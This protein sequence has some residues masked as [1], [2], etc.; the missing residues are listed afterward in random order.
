MT[1]HLGESNVMTNSTS[2][3]SFG[4]PGS[5]VSPT[6]ASR[7]RARLPARLRRFHRDES[8][9]M[10]A[11]SVFFFLIM[12][13]VGGIGVDFMHY[14]M[15]RTRLQKTLDRAVL[16][17]ADMQ[18]EL[19]PVAVVEDYLNKAGVD[20]T[21][22]GV[23][24]VD[25]GVSYR[26]VTARAT[27]NVPTQFIHM[28]GI[29]ALEAPAQA[30]AAESIEGIEIVLV[31][32]ISNS[33]NS[34]DR[35]INL[36]PAAREFI[37]TV[38]SFAETDNV[39]IS[40]IPYNT[41][42]NVGPNLLDYYNVSSEHNFSNCVDFAGD[43]FNSA[44][45]SPAQP[46]E[47]TSHFSVWFDNQGGFPAQPDV[48]Q[49]PTCPNWAGTESMLMSSDVAALKARI[50]SLVAHGNTS[51]DVAMKWASTMLDPGTRPVITQMIAD[52]H[53]AATNAGRPVNYHEAGVGKIIVV[54]TDGQNTTQYRLPSWARDGASNVHYHSGSTE[55]LNDRYSI[56]DAAS[57]RYFWRQDNDWHDSAYG[58][59]D[60]DPNNG[61]GAAVR[62]SHPELLAMNSLRAVAEHIYTPMVGSTEAWNDWYNDIVSGADNLNGAAKDLRLQNICGAA[63]SNGVVIYS[64]GFEA[65]AHGN[66]QMRSCAS[67]PSHFFDADGTSISD[68]FQAIAVSIAQLRLMQ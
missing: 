49:V 24:T 50:D 66:D 45:L 68:T 3:T 61:L 5:M 57:D 25:E 34:Y 35:L 64:I 22:D 63:K 19:D 21:L 56:Y 60:N 29:D 17:A 37:D 23:P 1:R 46:L 38:S 8:G 62:L 44:A 7:L 4:T 15:S 42:V 32:D 39:T 41:Q 31:L 9:V 6:A 16:A 12:L 30:R 2:K 10:I 13:I 55:D 40:I 28:L 65:T 51:I 43:D 33:M 59:D 52:G 58:D 20:A 53:L 48:L 27:L 14:E 54:M 36:K 11:Y 26:D 47:R 67:S 18:Q